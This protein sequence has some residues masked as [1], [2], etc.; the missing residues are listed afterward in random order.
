MQVPPGNTA[1]ALATLDPPGAVVENA[2]DA[3]VKHISG[4]DLKVIGQ[5]FNMLFMQYVSD[6][7]IAELRWLANQRQYLGLYDPE[8]EKAMSPNRSKAYPKITRVKVISVLS[9]IMNLM[10]QGNERNWELQ[11]APW[12]DMKVEE[13]IGRAHV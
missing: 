1:Q 4:N 12:P 7:R 5:R 2:M 6:R 3:P 13:E 9:R 11:A 10:F 8:V